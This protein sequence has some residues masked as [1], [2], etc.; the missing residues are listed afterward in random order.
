MKVRDSKIII[1]YWNIILLSALI[2]VLYSVINWLTPVW[3]DDLDYGAEGH[4]FSDI[5]HREF[6]D[7][8]YANGRIFSHT[9]VQ[10][11]LE[12]WA[13]LYLIC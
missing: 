8:L 11:L 5:F 7:Y 13:N 6:H 9:L 4:T 2:V 12:Y 1:Q 3:C 10:L